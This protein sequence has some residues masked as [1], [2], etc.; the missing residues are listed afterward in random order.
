M[1]DALR[2]PETVEDAWLRW[3]EAE[4][5]SLEREELLAKA[6][7]RERPI[8]GWCIFP[9]CDNHRIWPISGWCVQHDR[10]I[11]TYR[12]QLGMDFRAGTINVW[13]EFDRLRAGVVLDDRFRV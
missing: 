9:G 10:L 4:L 11:G 8:D 1:S 2:S 5:A 13:C 12:A 3:F 7:A 6:A